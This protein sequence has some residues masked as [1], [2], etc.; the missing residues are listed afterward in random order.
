MK[1]FLKHMLKP[2]SIVSCLPVI[3]ILSYWSTHRKELLAI[4]LIIYFGVIIG[5]TIKYFCKDKFNTPQ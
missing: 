2:M 3:G 4:C 5:S 1:K